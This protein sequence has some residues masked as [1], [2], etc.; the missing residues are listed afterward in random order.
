MINK[1]IRILF[2]LIFIAKGFIIYFLTITDY[3]IVSASEC[4]E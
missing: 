2:L 1:H 4:Q 3:G